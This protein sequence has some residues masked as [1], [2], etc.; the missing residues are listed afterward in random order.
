MRKLLCALML[1]CVLCLAGAALAEDMVYFGDYAVPADATAIDLGDVKVKD[2]AAFEA[3]LDQLPNLQRVDMFATEVKKDR[4]NEL[5][6]RYPNIRFGWTMVIATTDHRHYI[7]TDATAFSTLHNNKFKTHSSADFEILKYCP[8]LLALDVGH[9]GIDDLS[10]LYDLPKLRVLILACNR[11]TDITPLASLTDL[12][13][14]EL[15]KNSITDITP[16]AGL[17]NLLDLNI[18]FNRI[19]D[20]TPLYGLT[21]LERLWIYNSNNYSEDIPVPKDVVN[22]IK[23]ALPNAYVDSTHYSTEGGWRVHERYDIIFATFNSGVD[24]YHSGTYVPFD[25]EPDGNV[26]PVTVHAIQ[27]MTP[28]S[29]LETAEEIAAPAEPVVTPEP[30]PTPV[31]MKQVRVVVGK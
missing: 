2:F 22:G 27:T 14:A 25:R 23:A 5:A 17:T 10:F 15:F 1:V 13:Y 19:K 8:D 26:Q 24:R 12:Q 4:I 11:I 21:N 31:P 16:L 30:V 9:N 6:E 28:V 29:A 7:R 18:C 3:F 20:W